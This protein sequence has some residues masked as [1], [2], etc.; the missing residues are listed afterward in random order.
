MK[1]GICFGGLLDKASFFAAAARASSS[2]SSSSLSSAA[3]G[4]PRFSGSDEILDCPRACELLLRLTSWL[5]AALLDPLCALPESCVILEL[6][7]MAD[8]L[9]PALQERN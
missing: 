8:M 2:P 6:S 5:I 4:D 1:G 9:L 3:V 7:L